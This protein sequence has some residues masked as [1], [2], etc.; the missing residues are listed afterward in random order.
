MTSII[1]HN[2]YSRYVPS[3]KYVPTLNELSE[4]CCEFGKENPQFFP[5]SPHV[6]WAFQGVP[7]PQNLFPDEIVIGAK[8]MSHIDMYE[9]GLFTFVSGSFKDAVESVEPN[10]H[11]FHPF[12]P[13]LKTGQKSA[14][15]FYVMTVGQI[16]TDEVVI[17]STRLSVT[18]FP[19]GR[20]TVRPPGS[21]DSGMVTISRAQ[22][23]KMEMWISWQ[24][25]QRIIVSTRLHDEMKNRG[26][27]SLVFVEL[28]ECELASEHAK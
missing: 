5:I 9:N 3:A 6:W 12:F 2:P 22:T 7:L 14:L 17:E 10:I 28:N 15:P 13:T 4:R 27:K 25:S 1:I 11:Q 18:A 20:L 19:S 21:D 26:I 8:D 16:C 24:L 23:S